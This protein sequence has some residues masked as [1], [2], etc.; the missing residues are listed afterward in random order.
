MLHIYQMK[1]LQQAETS[2]GLGRGRGSQQQ[3]RL[4]VCRQLESRIDGKHALKKLLWDGQ[5]SG[6]GRR[7]GGGELVGIK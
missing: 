3:H 5:G 6:E 2:P 1:D 4:E 7:A